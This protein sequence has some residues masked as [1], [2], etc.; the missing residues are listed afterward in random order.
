[1]TIAIIIPMAIIIT[2]AA[3]ANR[4]LMVFFTTSW[5]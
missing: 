2:E 5:A 3:L 4:I 1:M